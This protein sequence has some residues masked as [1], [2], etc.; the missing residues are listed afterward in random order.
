MANLV[1]SGRSFFEA[2]DGEGS[3]G[4][5]E[6]GRTQA[7][8][9]RDAE[10]GIGH[11][12]DEEGV[13]FVGAVEEVLDLLVGGGTG[14]FFGHDFSGLGYLNCFGCFYNLFW[15]VLIPGVGFTFLFGVVGWVAW[16][17]GLRWAF[18]C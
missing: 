5:V 7:D 10:A 6:I 17:R 2:L 4:E 18:F 16:D 9:F 14:V 1:A 13:F 12:E 11:E 8:D 15:W 3:F